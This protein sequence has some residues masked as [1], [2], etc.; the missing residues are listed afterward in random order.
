MIRTLSLVLA[1]AS[2]LHGATAQ[3]A[4]RSATPEVQAEL[5]ASV[6]AVHPGEQI[7]LGLQQ[8]IIPHWHTYWVNPG[9][10]GLATTIAW[11]LPAGASAGDIQWPAP[12]RFNTGP[13]ANYGYENEV[14]LLSTLRVPAGLQP[15]Q[16]FP[17][18]AE[19]SWLVCKEVCIPQ[20]LSLDLDLPVVAPGSPRET[21]NPAI[22]AARRRLPAA[23][24][25]Q[26]TIESD[27]KAIL[28]HVSGA[29]IAGLKP[30]EAWF[31]ASEWGKTTHDG[32][33]RLR[34]QGDRLELR[35]KAGEAPGAVG[36]PLDGVLAL[37]AADGT[38]KAYTIGAPIKTA[39]APISVDAPVAST[40]AGTPDDIQLGAALLLALLGGLILN[41]MP[42]VF[43]VLSI[44]AL[45]LL[46]HAGQSPWQA[47]L[48][49]LA[50]T[51]GVLA[52]F[53]VLAGVLLALKAGGAEVGWGFQFQSPVFVLAV[54]YL[55]FAVGLSL[56][57][58]LELGA[59]AAGIGASLAD[60]PGYAGS[61]FT[62]VLATVVATP[63]TAPFMGAALGFALGQ[64]APALF[65]VFLSLGLGLALPYLLLSF[66]PALQRRLPRPGRWMER[67]KEILAF[68]MYGAAVWLVWVLAR[69]AG[70]DAIAIALGGMLAIAFAA[71]LY[72]HSHTARPLARHGSRGLAAAAVALALAGGYAGIGADNARAATD[73]APLGT[74]APHANQAWEPYS[75]ARLDAL[76][77]EGKP[78]F[79]NFTAA[80]CIT[81]LAN[82]KVALS[83]DTV[84]DAFR[85]AGIT[86]LKGDWT[87]QDP[88]ISAHL[89]EFG[90][91]GVP[92]YLFYPGGTA[93]T[94][95]V[96]P[97]LLTPAIVRAAI[98]PPS[99]I[100]SI[101]E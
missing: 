37:H 43:P 78:V 27:G 75:K 73:G 58:A 31:Y 87:H 76:R 32:P 82:E 59:P 17:V 53:A 6:S 65:A 54:A 8:K 55:M 56:S 23:N 99:S 79:V 84:Q 61:F 26:T 92:L 101:Q 49:G 95:K 14:T 52:S 5:L 15:G 25:W 77:A 28:L 100:A 50:Y 41:L 1:T 13:V 33:Q 88:Q 93:S 18:K 42:C 3:A 62:G 35:V 57:G 64:P 80:W 9:D 89:A 97:Q 29:G 66:W 86:Y 47:R 38:I 22:E 94:P 81:C 90:R 46:R 21:G 74:A 51:A 69:Q 70:P 11:T 48:Q 45:S 10:S 34:I 63:C 67:L 12:H 2:V 16:R 72:R 7:E 20:Q 40:A 4:S 36:T 30:A 96:L 39:S 19:V 60:K 71:W 98:A 68:P 44:K 91:S 24:P 83:S 85:Q